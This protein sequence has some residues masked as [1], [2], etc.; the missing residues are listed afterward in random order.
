MPATLHPARVM[1]HHAAHVVGL[2]ISRITLG[3]PSPTYSP[4]IANYQSQYFE[5]LHELT[6]AFCILHELDLEVP[7]LIQ[8]G[9]GGG[10]A[11]IR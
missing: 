9:V 4:A 8:D 2:T 11:G 6:P 1:L 7:N 10:L 3:S 5:V